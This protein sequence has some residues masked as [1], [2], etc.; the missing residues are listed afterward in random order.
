ML[1]Q[2]ANIILIL[3]LYLSRVFS[4]NIFNLFQ[5]LLQTLRKGVEPNFG[6]RIVYKQNADDPGEKH[7]M[8]ADTIELGTENEKESS[9]GGMNKSA[10]A[11]PFINAEEVSNSTELYPDLSRD[12]NNSRVV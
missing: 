12:L 11:V 7:I 9:K 8:L 10:S 6:T 1:L 5:R 3:W 4:W 2:Y